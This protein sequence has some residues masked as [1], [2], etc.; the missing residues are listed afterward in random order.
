MTL[1]F[2]EDD[3][4]V[5]GQIDSNVKALLATSLTHDARLRSLERH[6]WLQRGIFLGLGGLLATK[7]PFL[8]EYF[9]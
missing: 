3:R 8:S 4:F 9:K 5:L 6:R 1:H 2:Q 7:F